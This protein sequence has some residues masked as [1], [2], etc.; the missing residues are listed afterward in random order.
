MIDAT[1]WREVERV[2][3]LTLDS[4]PGTWARILDEHCSGDPELRLEV[5][6]LLARH[7][8]A[9]RYLEAPPAAVAAA[10]LKEARAHLSGV[11]DRRIG[12]YR[13]VRQI[14]QGGTSH[15]FLAERV[16]GQFRQEVALKLL[17]PGHDSEID[18]GRFRA[19]R[20]ILA[21]LNHPSV[22]RLHDG[23]VTDDGLPYLVM[24]LVN[25]EPIDKFCNTHALPVRRRLEMFLT[26]A[27]ATQY[28]HR[29]L[30]V[31][32]DL[33]PSNILVTADG[34]VKLLDFGLAKLLDSHPVDGAP[35]LTTQRWMTPEY[36]APEQV[37]GQPATTLTDVYQLGVVLYELLTGALPFGT[38]Q[39]SAFELERAILE[40][41][42][43]A[44]SVSRRELRGDLDAIVL[45]ALRKEPEKRYASAH[46]FAEDVRRHL[47]GHPVQAQRQ[48][49]V[50]R[51]RRF[52]LRNRW[53]VAATSLGVILVAAYAITLTVQRGHVERALAEAT[54][55][56][57][58]AQQVTDMMLELFESSERGKAFSDTLTARELLKRA[59]VRARGLT[60]RPA[61]V[62]QMLDV[63]G[64]IHLQFG[65]YALAGESY[66]E[67]LD[68]RRD[69]LG[70]RHPDVATSLHNISD[71]AMKRAD[72]PAAI[73]GY[74]RALEIRRE[75]FGPTHALTLDSHYWLA[76]AVHESGDSKGAKPIFA[77]WM[78]GVEAGKPELTEER[79]TQLTR[80]GQLYFY[81]PDIEDLA[82]AERLY[83]DAVT[84]R[85][86][87]LGPRHPSVGLAMSKVAVV[88]QRRRE[89]R[90]SEEMVREA[91]AI[92]RNAYPD[93]HPDVAQVMRIL[94]I[95]L[96]QQRQ[97]AEAASLYHSIDSMQRRF[98][99]PEHF[100]IGTGF[101]DLG[102]VYVQLGDF[103]RAE[104]YLREALRFYARRQGDENLMTMGARVSLG[105][106]LVEQGKLAEAE[107][108]LLR[109]YA[110]Y[111]DRN[112][113]GSGPLYVRVSLQALV[114]LYEAQGREKEAAK[115]R[116]LLD[117]ARGTAPATAS[118]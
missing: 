73:D 95:S 38:R 34:Q 47:S 76:N 53:A 7:A 109:G 30:V 10:L 37:R 97:F 20:Q 94:A 107:P 116:S 67:A 11:V 102:N 15:V 71:V 83:K 90:E 49:A 32:R 54:V 96:Q 55:E 86:A 89:S 16:D 5:E 115:Y 100:F 4:D 99:G 48:T 65:D 3:D 43:Q 19:E 21:S 68:I 18:Q 112:M 80:L 113:P 2:L 14:G 28:A 61:V 42:P 8:S 39:Q 91:L 104:A 41:E 9:Q 63:I 108:L 78:Q 87:S 74:R 72:Y 111:R 88:H 6:A 12:V 58:K 117:S 92:M 46:D 101:N 98:L 31:H 29:N 79:A 17:R 59:K 69:V 77:E 84:A 70:P 23:G 66:T 105:N 93:G 110:A 57:E 25:G 85:R 118:R 27:D 56:A 62:A 33:K 24:E 50:Y 64:Q 82:K 103:P 22:A 45:K 106:V 60:T 75:R 36:A 40:R 35:A 1:R 44:P 26:V 81:S 114:K 13:I 51:A 52:V